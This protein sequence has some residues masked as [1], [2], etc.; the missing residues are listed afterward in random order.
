MYICMYIRTV[1]HMVVQQCLYVSALWCQ[2]KNVGGD[3]SIEYPGLC[4]LALNLHTGYMAE[5]YLLHVI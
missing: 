2:D 4:L 5:H 3:T 1:I